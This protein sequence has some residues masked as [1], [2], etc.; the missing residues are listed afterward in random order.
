MEKHERHCTL[1]PH[2]ACRWLISGV[3]RHA[4][5][6]HLRSLVIALRQNAPLTD[7]AID[8]LRMAVG[9]CPACMLA[10]LR[11]SGVEYHY[12]AKGL[13]LWQYGAEV[14]SFRLR[15]REAGDRDEFGAIQASWL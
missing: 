11:Q 10:A 1:N 4:E 8:G 15:E 2:R 6:I 9:G 13:N 12:D 14:E 7:V 5:M 3:H